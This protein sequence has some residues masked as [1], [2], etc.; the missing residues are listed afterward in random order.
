MS[1]CR[2]GCQVLTVTT[3]L[4]LVSSQFF[5]K[6]RLPIHY[7]YNCC[8]YILLQF[9]KVY[10]HIIHLNTIL[11]YW[12]YL[13][14][15]LIQWRFAVGF[16]HLAPVKWHLASLVSTELIRGCSHSSQSIQP[17]CW[18]TPPGSEISSLDKF[19]TVWNT[20]HPEKFCWPSQA[21]RALL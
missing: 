17:F 15:I 12:N 11:W 7:C 20:V 4:S 21:S 19:V 5:I 3:L 10:R 9:F 13:N 1:A 6:C 16:R 18:Q 8:D 2:A 14:G